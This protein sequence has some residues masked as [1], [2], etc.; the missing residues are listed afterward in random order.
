MCS[1]CGRCVA[2]CVTVSSVDVR[3]I[4]NKIHRRKSQLSVSFI[5]SSVFLSVASRARVVTFACYKYM[6]APT[7]VGRFYVGGQY[8]SFFI[9]VCLTWAGSATSGGR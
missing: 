4:R 7:A 5:S 3:Y 2:G 8:V 9:S 6:Y 1:Q